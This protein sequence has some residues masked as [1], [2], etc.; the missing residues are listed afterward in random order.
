MMIVSSAPLHVVQ[1]KAETRP[2]QAPIIVI[3]DQATIETVKNKRGVYEL[4]NCDDH[5]DL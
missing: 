1:L 2:K 4:L 3:L 5:R